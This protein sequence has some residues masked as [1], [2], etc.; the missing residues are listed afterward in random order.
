MGGSPESSGVGNANNTRDFGSKLDPSFPFILGAMTG[1]LCK[2][3]YN[4]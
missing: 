4:I 1:G 3:S 2:E